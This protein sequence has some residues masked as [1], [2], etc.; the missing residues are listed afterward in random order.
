GVPYAKLWRWGW[1]VV[2]DALGWFA[3]NTALTLVVQTLVQVNVQV[4]ALLISAL[5][6]TARADVGA[7]GVRAVLH[8]PRALGI[9]FAALAVVIV[10]LGY[11]D[12]MLTAWTD[13]VMTGRLQRRLHD[14]LL[15]LG[16]SYHRTHDVGLT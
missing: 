6:S 10:V 8:S 1:F 11:A 15:T 3:I 4:L 12:R 7:H 16:P 14:K 13:N 2:R 5:T 9:T